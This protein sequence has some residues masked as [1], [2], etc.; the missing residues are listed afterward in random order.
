MPFGVNRFRNQTEIMHSKSARKKS[1]STPREKGV[2]LIMVAAVLAILAALGTG[3]YTMTLMATRSAVH[4]SD[5]VRAEM[6]A[7]AGIEYAI[8]GLR[9]QAYKKTEDP[10]DPWY[11]VDYCNGAAKRISFPDNSVLHDG[12]DDDND[13][14]ADN[15]DEINSPNGKGKNLP[16]SR[17]LA[18]TVGT[19]S[20]VFKLSVSDAASKININAGDNLGVIL[21][22]LCRVI[23]SPLVAADLDALQ[24]R[25]WAQEIQAIGRPSAPMYATVSN[26]NDLPI[27]LDL[28]YQLFDESGNPSPVGRP[29]RRQ[30]PWSTTAAPDGTALYGDGYALAG[31]RANHGPFKSISEV[32]N[33]LTYVERSAPPDGVPNDPLEQLEI[34]IKFAAIQDY[35]TI[36]SWADTNT[37][38]V[39]KFEW[40]N[41]LNSGYSIAIDRDKSWI[42]PVPNDPLSGYPGDADAFRKNPN[43]FVNTRGSLLGC[44]VSIMNGHGSGQLRA[45]M[46]NGTDWIRI[47]P[48][49]T[50]DPGPISSYMIISREAAMYQRMR[51][52]G[53]LTAFPLPNPLSTDDLLVPVVDLNNNIV[54]NPNVDYSQYPLCIHRSPVNVNTASDKVLEALL[55]GINIQHGH[56]MSVGTDADLALTKKAW[57]YWDAPNNAYDDPHHQEAYLLT[58]SGLKRV[59]VCAGK[60]ALNRPMPWVTPADDS[61]FGYLN[62]YGNMGT[63]NFV[64]SSF[65][66]EVH[67]LAYRIIMARTRTPG[68]LAGA[69]DPDPTTADGA[70]PGY[71]RGPFRSWDDLYFR[72]IKPW[73][74][75]R[76]GYFINGKMTIPNSGNPGVTVGLGQTSVARII[77]A[78]MN[79]N[80]DI[81]KFNPNIEWIDRWGRNFTELEG[82]MAY[83]DAAPDRVGPG[84]SFDAPVSNPLTI[85][86]VPI[87]AVSQATNGSRGGGGAQTLQPSFVND[88][89]VDAGSYVIRSFRYKSD[90]MLDKTDLNRSTTEFAFDSKGIYSIESI[91]TITGSTGVQAERKIQALVKLYDVWSETTQRQFTQGIIST[92]SAAIDIATA[93]AGARGQIYSG[94]V[95]RDANPANN[96]KDPQHCLPLITQP[97]PLVPIDYK[98]TNITGGLAPK[99]FVDVRGAADQYGFVKRDQ[100]A[101][102]VVANRIL[103]AAYDGQILL[104]TNTLGFDKNGDHDTFL[105]SFNG[106]LDTNTCIGNGREQSKM[107]HTPASDGFKYRVVD[108][109]GLLGILNDTLIDMDTDLPANNPRVYRWGILSDALKG[110]NPL[111]Y[112][113]NISLRM[114]DLRTD[115]VYLSGPGV[116]GNDSTLKYVFGD[117]KTITNDSFTPGNAKLNLDPG[118][119]T[120]NIVS[121]WL[122]PAWHHNDHRT[123][124]LFDATNPGYGYNE[125]AARAFYLK[126]FGSMDWAAWEWGYE[127]QSG[128]RPRTD[129][130]DMSME[131]N[132]G[133]GQQDGD[134]DKDFLAFLHGGFNWV[135]PNLTIPPPGGPAPLPLNAHLECPSYRTQPFRWCYAGMRW[136]LNA[137][138]NLS[139]IAKHGGHW[140]SNDD[141]LNPTNSILTT[142]VGRPFISTQTN[143][144]KP[145]GNNFLLKSYWSSLPNADNGFTEPCD[146]GDSGTTPTGAAESANPTNNFG[147]S[148]QPAKWWWA[149]P[150]GAESPSTVKVFG[151]N[152]LNQD[153]KMWLYHHLPS[154]G[155]YGVIDEFKISSL[156][157]LLNGQP[158]IPKNTK[159]RVTRSLPNLPPGEQTCS[160]YYLP[161][162]PQSKDQ[163]PTF[164]SQT[165]LQSLKGFSTKTTSPEYV[166][167]VRVTWSVFT[168]RFLQE[169]I[170]PTVWRNEYIT[171]NMSSQIPEP[172]LFRG[173]FDYDKYNE[174]YTGIEPGIVIFPWGVDR[175]APKDYSTKGAY[176]QPHATQGVEIELLNNGV[177]IPGSYETAP[178]NFTFKNTAGTFL[179]PDAENR[180]LDSTGDPVSTARVRTDQLRYLV[181]FR[182]PVDSLT[183]LNGGGLV[184][185]N[186]VRCVDPAKQYLLDT[187]VFDDISVTYF[188]TPRILEY[189]DVTE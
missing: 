120:G 48:P 31:Y 104:A 133:L 69:P 150:S 4:Y 96:G 52:N 37:V 115:G 85:N 164:T 87:F 100:L 95:A 106:D 184:D 9:A 19:S 121:M 94:Q 99:D 82:V 98:L 172:N 123:H 68:K 33:A 72:V 158:S 138:L 8:A 88:G 181:R 16:Y 103:P 66:N 28:Y 178:G 86:S 116:C 11:M 151:M 161:L 144:E 110:L 177:Q 118:S 180:Y 156:D 143:P 25:R 32:K 112:W 1:I 146:I 148:G 186:G 46:D 126:K 152:N 56:P 67:E 15:L 141:Y 155:T 47:E 122:K 173:P 97:E 129:D 38:C 58:A 39:G 6:M 128:N 101:P 132:T 136:H 90:E 13:G 78:N 125:T 64:G 157:T 170:A 7:K 154:D 135:T 42:P 142:T 167:L 2:T 70:F 35:I 91:G 55:L 187:P 54:S 62:N 74:D 107:P 29:A 65:C 111:N 77:M 145:G 124:P 45:I 17:A 21:D 43:V 84:W 81:L 79:P 130:L 44:F 57:K 175:P 109:C 92:G 89:S 73:D 166:T 50:V 14:V 182:Y 139:G 93:G 23:G 20:D 61:K 127:F 53:T 165:M 3:F 76:S 5:S 168:P 34:E 189:K 59:P 30:T 36:D 149:D 174:W 41:E 75:I 60:P 12:V 63:P 26:G 159:D 188:I 119:K 80:T 102:D 113:E 163:C 134:R 183:D 162:S 185:N 147:S 117:G 51:R 160:R 171:R 18:N 27:N 24:P 131:A 169:Y 49:F 140:A 71:E 105:A 40:I 179:N 10:S 114:G 22:N 137:S 83:T 108:T 153:D 176:A